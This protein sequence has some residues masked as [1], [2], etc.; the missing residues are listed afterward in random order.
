[1]PS[2]ALWSYPAI[3][4]PQPE[5]LK[6]S[7][8]NSRPS[9]HSRAPF[10]LRTSHWEG[11]SARRRH[12]RRAT[13]VGRPVCNVGIAWPPVVAGSGRIPDWPAFPGPR[14]LLARS[15]VDSQD[16]AAESATAGQ[17]VRR[18]PS[19]T[20]HSEAARWHQT[21]SEVF[22]TAPRSQE[23]SAL[24]VMLDTTRRTTRCC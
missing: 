10:A 1:M 6:I 19:P 18:I 16:L 11:R 9:D 12:C 5:N 4:H 3:Y 2:A 17:S 7:R 13:A 24:S 15:H 21:V 22:S 14:R 8:R 20:G 23:L